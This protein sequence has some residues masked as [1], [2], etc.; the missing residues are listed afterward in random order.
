MRSDNIIIYNNAL[1]TTFL[2]FFYHKAS[3]YHHHHNIIDIVIIN[4]MTKLVIIAI[5]AMYVRSFCPHFK[6]HFNIQT[7]ELQM[8]LKALSLKY[9]IN[10]FNVRKFHKTKILIFSSKISL[11][12]H[13]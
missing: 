3:N 7:C 5:T 12:S 1:N 8:L 11:L 9:D 6:E 2:T 10:V 13:Y 4:I